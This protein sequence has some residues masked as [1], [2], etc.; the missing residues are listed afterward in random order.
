FFGYRKGAFTGAADDRIGFFQAANGGTLM[1]DEVA[2]LPL[3]M[4]VKLLR[5]IQERRVRRVGATSEEVVDVRLISATH[6]DLAEWVEQ[7]RFRQDLYY[8]LN[9]IELR[10]PPLRERKSD[11]GLLAQAILDRLAGAGKASLGAEALRVLE[12]H[13]FPGNVRELE[14]ILERALAFASGAVIQ[15]AD[16]ALKDSVRAASVAEPVP[17]PAPASLPAEPAAVP[18]INP[19]APPRA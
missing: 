14:N 4:Q 19:A 6:R 9:V 12:A 5:A 3:A 1:L 16:L 8:R 2:D 17:E 15:P 18:R 7:G 13:A 10:L 11:I